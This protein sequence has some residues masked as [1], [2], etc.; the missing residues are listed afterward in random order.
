M[1]GLRYAEPGSTYWPV[2]WGPAFAVT[3][4]AVEALSGPVHVV[5]WIVV[6]VVLAG[7]AWLW[8]HARRR[9]CR[10]EL[11]ADTL[12]Q[13]R[14]SLPINEITEI[15]DESDD[16]PVGA[17]VLGGGWTVPNRFGQVPLRLHGGHV[18]LAWAKDPAALRAALRSLVDS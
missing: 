11:S 2:L 18:V 12:S 1:T 14:E 8:V 3:G 17:R 6:G 9:T 10:V 16:A 15:V 13:G 4:A 5:D 7:F